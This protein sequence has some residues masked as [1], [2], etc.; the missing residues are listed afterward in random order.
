MS[1]MENLNGITKPILKKY[2]PER[3]VAKSVYGKTGCIWRQKLKRKLGTGKYNATH[4]SVLRL[5]QHK[6]T[7]VLKLE[8]FWIKS[9]KALLHSF[10]RDT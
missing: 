4:C 3:S 7:S 9:F 5:F 2:V 1:L 10:I 6:T 8:R